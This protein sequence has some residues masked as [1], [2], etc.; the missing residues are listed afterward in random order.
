[1]FER[2][3]AELSAG[4]H[5]QTPLGSRHMA[6]RASSGGPARTEHVT[7]H[8]EDDT[9]MN[10]VAHGNASKP[11]KSSLVAAPKRKALLKPE[12]VDAPAQDGFGAGVQGV[13][14][15]GRPPVESCAV[16]GM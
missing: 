14:D 8:T 13:S 1:M 2:V 16:W 11:P 15:R 12:W 10:T 4:F 6:G 3:G 5:L 9:R 7:P